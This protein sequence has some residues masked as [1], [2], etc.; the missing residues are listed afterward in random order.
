MTVDLSD[1]K[2]LKSL[3]RLNEFNKALTP[4]NLLVMNIILIKTFLSVS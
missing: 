3:H 1:V 4:E 2:F